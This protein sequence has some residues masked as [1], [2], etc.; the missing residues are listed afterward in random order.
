V[1]AA[2]FVKAAFYLT[3]VAIP[4]GLLS[5]LCL[6]AMG[7]CCG[8]AIRDPEERVASRRL[9]RSRQIARLEQ[10]IRSVSA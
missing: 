2:R 10:R 7:R 9:R 6:R 1:S 5:F 3:L 4:F 8:R